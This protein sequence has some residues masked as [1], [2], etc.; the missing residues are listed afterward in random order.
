MTA[1]ILAFSTYTRIPMCRVSDEKAER[2]LKW[3]L[4]AF[5]LTG[6]VLGFIQ[7]AAFYLMRMRHVHT[8]AAA[9]I[10]TVIPLIYT[11]GI[12]FDGL[13]DVADALSSYK[14]KDEKIRI[15]KDP[16]IGAFA[17]IH[18]IIYILLYFAA[19]SSIYD[20]RILLYAIPFIYPAGRVMTAL[21]LITGRE[22]K[23]SGMAGSMTKDAGDVK[24][25][26]IILLVLQLVLYV[27]GMF[28]FVVL[29]G[30]GFRFYFVA[31][32]VIIASALFYIFRREKY[33]REFGRLS[34]DMAGDMLCRIELLCLL[35]LAAGGLIM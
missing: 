28:A 26:L 25:M 11:G 12:H 7:F 20:R 32:A 15:L 35:I 19:L 29:H 22:D 14:D 2:S 16:H 21:L 5:P 31:A 34:G 18:A 8:A 10:L 13:M 33:I 6:I 3:I 27:G 4:C 17:V 23:G 24:R 30:I 1:I 9:A